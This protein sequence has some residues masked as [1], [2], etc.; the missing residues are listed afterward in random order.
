M[1]TELMIV[2]GVSDVQL[3]SYYMQNV[4]GWK[5]E[6][7]NRL[8]VV[9]LDEYEHIESL[10]NEDNQLILCGVGG[11]GKINHFV[12]VHH[13]N[14]ML[15]ERDISSVMIVADRDEKSDSKIRRRANDAFKDI[16]FKAGEWYPNGIFDS[17]G[18]NKEI[19]TYLLIIP[20]NEQG[21]L[22]K[23]IIDAL[24]DIPRETALIQEVITFVD[25][26]KSKLLPELKTI[27]KYNK[28]AVGTFFS[29]RDPKNAM[30]SFGLCI[31]KIDWNNSKSLKDLFLPFGLFG[32]NKS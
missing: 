6:K 4:F 26:L 31:S 17:F 30:R 9:P 5:Y 22:E 18:Q 16:S 7:N 21:A 23:V 29:V 19:Y 12:E 27:N 28:A 11:V 8:G 13:V 2:E 20:V 25:S 32:K 15:V 24:Y 14:D 1:M 10:S 3:I